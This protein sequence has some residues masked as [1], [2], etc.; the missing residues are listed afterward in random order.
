MPYTNFPRQLLSDEEKTKE[1]CEQNLDAMAPYIAQ[2]NNN[3]YINDRFKDIRNYQAYHGHFDPKDYEHITDQYGTPFPARMT[4]YNI[5]APKID[6]LTS[7]ELR[8]PLETKV[9]SINKSAVNRKK[10]AKVSMVMEQML[11]DI[12]KEINETMGMDITQDNVDFDIPDD[13]ET[14]MRY[15][16]KEA[17]EVV[18]ESG[19]EYLKE[20]YRWKDLFKNGFRD[21]LVLGKVFYKIDVK[22]GDPHVR[23][24]DPRNIAF[25]SSI[26]SDYI[27]ESQWVVEQ[28]WL[29]VNEIL[30]E[31]GDELTKEDVMELENM[32]QISSGSE[33]AHYNTSIEWLNYDASTG[34]RIRLIQGE[35]KSIRAIRFKVSENKYDPDNP[36]RK[37]VNDSYRPRKGETIE[38]KYVDDI[39]EGTKIGGR[40]TTRCRR[41]PNQVRSVDDAGST[42]LSYVGC[43]HNMSAGRITS[44]V[45]VLKHIQTLYNVVMYHIELTLSRAGGKAVVYDVSQMP[46]NIGM[47]MQ[48]VLYH[49]KNDGIIPI[50]SRDEGQDTARFNQFQ[51]VD[52]TLSNSVQQLVNLKLMLEQTAGQVCGISPQRE[53]AVAQYEAVGNVQR[54][55]MQSNL[56]TENWF[57]QHSEVK[58]RVI[59]RVCGLMKICWAQGKRLGY[60]LGDGAFK[61]LDILPDIALN[62]YG[63]YINQGAKDDAI[64]QAVTQLSQAALQSGSITLLDVIKVLK[65]DSLSEAEHVLEN[66]IKEMQSQAK[67][68]QE[69]QQSILQA[70]AEQ[71][72]TKMQHE[73]QLK[74]MDSEARL[75]VAK[76]NTRAKI[77]VANI[78]ADLE[79]NMVSDRL[80]GAIQRDA[81]KSEYDKTVRADKMKMEEKKMKEDRDEKRKD[82]LA[83]TKK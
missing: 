20:K 31:F 37:V 69:Q 3:L 52:F 13:I 64:K 51:Q 5:I 32:R 33:L 76:E 49:I 68:A 71:E 57:F 61:L 35:W 8:R 59:E 18:A 73:T 63:V 75:K 47:D 15:T 19:I 11:G 58:K 41:R 39:W 50:N 45:D 62:D 17:I 56:V 54:T 82:R 34:V 14:Y 66:G 55:V 43:T 42:P 23:R 6:L 36:F 77:E 53:G 65:A 83:K 30:D 2:Y 26:E 16:Y 40:I 48:T 70:Q 67:A 25:D 46:S 38:T 28:R 27:D 81:A 80:K 78:Q 60:V 79:A 44:L 22:N 4:N 10:D 9:S 21:F 72:Q 29:S 12:K 7:E 24:V 1:W 74:Q